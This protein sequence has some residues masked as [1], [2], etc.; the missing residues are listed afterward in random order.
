MYKRILVILLFFSS[1]VAWAGSRREVTPFDTG[2]RFARYGLQ[3]DGSRRAE[4]SFP[5]RPDFDDS[6]W[7]QLDLPHDWG[8]EG[9]FRP[10]LDGYTGKLPWQ[11]IGW[12]RKSFT[13]GD[14]DGD[15]RFYLDFDGAMAYA[16]VWLNG[17]KVG[18]WPYGYTS[19]RVDLTPCLRR[20]GRNVVAVRLNT[21]NLGSRWYPGSGIYRHVRLTRTSPVHVGQWGVFVTTPEVTNEAATVSVRLRIENHRDA[22]T[23][24]RYEVALSVYIMKIVEKSRRQVSLVSRPSS[25]RPQAPPRTVCVSECRRPNA[26]I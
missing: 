26:G 13:V 19:F 14:A 12:Y 1:V 17:I 20:N 25:C 5:Q 15:A 8:I 10:E 7:R 4:P 3:P 21:E 16:E 9:P 24:C 18:G 23:D 2:W 22:A 6:A 11:G